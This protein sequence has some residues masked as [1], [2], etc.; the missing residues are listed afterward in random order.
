MFLDAMARVALEMARLAG[1]IAAVLFV[2]LI[3]TVVI[4]IAAP[5]IGTFIIILKIQIHTFDK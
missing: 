3:R 4:V 1:V 2:R 5:S